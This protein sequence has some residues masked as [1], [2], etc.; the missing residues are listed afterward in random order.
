[1]AL[2]LL[3]H[4]YYYYCYYYYNYNTTTTT[5]LLQLGSQ[6]KNYPIG[7]KYKNICNVHNAKLLMKFECF[8][9]MFK[10]F[11]YCNLRKMAVVMYN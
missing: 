1:M 9:P 4:Y 8:A 7:K 6:F 10:I 3:R 2:L 11:H 5:I